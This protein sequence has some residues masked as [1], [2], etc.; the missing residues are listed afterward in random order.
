[1]VTDVKQYELNRIVD[2]IKNRQYQI[3]SS[4]I[5]DDMVIVTAE[6]T[7]TPELAA[8]KELEGT[9]IT[10]FLKSFGWAIQ[11][12]YF[13]DNKMVIEFNKEVKAVVP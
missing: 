8:T 12:T 6:K 1:M 5:K 2:M 10:N 3:T 4:S 7:F 11:A 13:R 9:W